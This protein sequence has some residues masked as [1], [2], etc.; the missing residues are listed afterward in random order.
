MKAIR[1]LDYMFSLAGLIALSPVFLLVALLVKL[2]SKG[3]I[4][5]LQNRVGKDGKDFKVYK[6]RTMYTN[7]D[8]KG[9]LT[10]GGKDNRVTSIGY[11][12]RKFKLDELPQLLNVLAGDMSIVGPRP[13][14]RRYVDL[15]TTEQRRVLSVRPGITDYASIAYRNENDL[16]ATAQNPEEMYIQEI[17]PRKIELNFNYINNRSIKTY[18]KII[19]KTLSTS[20]NDNNYKQT[21]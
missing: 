10:V 16:L 8:K 6:F 21:N 7:A 15:Y 17:L 5:Y 12:L 3:P 20:V 18:F 4:F 2:T 9:L 19:I 11:Y 1:L 13:E 14:V